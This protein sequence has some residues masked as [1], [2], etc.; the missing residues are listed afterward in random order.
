[1]FL[2]PNVRRHTQP[3]SEKSQLNQAQH[4]TFTKTHFTVQKFQ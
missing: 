4:S 3:D 2:H 1:M